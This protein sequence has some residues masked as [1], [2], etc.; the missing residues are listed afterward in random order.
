MKFK[1]SWLSFKPCLNAKCAR[2]TLDDWPVSSKGNLEQLN[3]QQVV[4][5]DEQMKAHCG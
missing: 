3:S 4:L 1:S 2:S 5:H